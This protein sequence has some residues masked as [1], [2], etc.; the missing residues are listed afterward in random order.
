MF[1]S[2]PIVIPPEVPIPPPRVQTTQPPRV[3]KVGPN[4]NLRS[5]G[6]KNPT[7]LYAL[8]TKCPKTH[9]ANSFTN[10]ISGVAQEYRYLIKVLEKKNWEISFANE[11]GQ[12][13]QGTRGVN[14][15][16]TVILIIKDQ[17]PKDKKVTYGKI[18]CEVK[19][20]KEEKERTRLTVCG[21]LLD[22]TENLSAPTSSVT[23]EKC[24]FNSVIS[25][26]GVRCLL[27]DI[28]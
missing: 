27:A 12:L 22:F 10:K 28:K 9:D 20:K 18:V 5:R 11:L 17:V 7:P 19:P 8:T 24:V 1:P 25:T 16:N 23:T 14:G 26:P 6:K 4:S 15:K 13:A 21:N 2:G 3:D